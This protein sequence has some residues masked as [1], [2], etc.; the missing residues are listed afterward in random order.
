MRNAGR[1]EPAPITPGPSPVPAVTPTPTPVKP[2]AAL[3]ADKVLS[4]AGAKRC[5]SR[6][7]LTLSL[8]KRATGPKVTSVRVTIG[9]GKAVTYKAAKLKVPIRLTGLPKGRFTVK[10]AV[11]MSD[12]TKVNLTRAYKTCAAKKKR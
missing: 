2:A 5:A 7:S 4:L 3:T 11:T 8:R 9:K 1:P 10:V 6:R 12:G